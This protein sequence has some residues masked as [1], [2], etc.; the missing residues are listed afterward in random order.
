M[1][2]IEAKAQPA[3]TPGP[4]PAPQ[5]QQ[6]RILRWTLT[7]LRW[8]CYLLLG[9][10]CIGI[11]AWSAAAILYASSGRSP[12]YVLAGVFLIAVVAALIFVRPR[13]LKWAVPP[14]FFLIVMAWY[15]SLKPS[16]DREWALDCDHLAWADIKG[17]KITL[18]N[19]R[20][21]EYG[22]SDTDFTPHWEDRTYDLQ[23]L[24]T[25]DLML[26]Y[27]GSDAI[28]HAMVTF[29]FDDGQY[30]NISI[31][32]RKERGESYSS[33]QGFFRQYELVYIFADERD[34]LRLRINYRQPHE[35]IYLY[36]TNVTPEHARAALLSYLDRANDLKEHPEWYNALTTNCAT[37]VLPHARAAGA[38]GEMSFDIL[39]SGYA[40]RQA[41]R[42]GMIDTSLP[43]EE[44]RRR[45]RINDVAIA[46]DH[47]PDFS[48]KIRAA[49]PIPPRWAGSQAPATRP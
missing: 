17:D 35:D 48:N 25:A 42:N 27:W 38:K 22:R 8:L 31:E 39:L 11:T 43:Y 2:E 10:V 14:V 21:F 44:L 29:D 41:Y 26:V 12:R 24:R 16:N 5:R 37:S 15:F 18:H 20:N 40:A 30:L 47:D 4:P 6:P 23:R 36:R 9:L 13:K 28:A 34:A 7:G 49:L 33:I 3:E 45:S 19:V 1:S 32:T 46:L